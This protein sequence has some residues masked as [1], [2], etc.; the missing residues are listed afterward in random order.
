MV[1]K[2]IWFYSYSDRLNLS[3]EEHESLDQAFEAARVKEGGIYV[4]DMDKS[5]NRADR[6]FDYPIEGFG[7]LT[8][9]EFSAVVQSAIGEDPSLS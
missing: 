2:K 9:E 5:S 1:Q 7:H 6:H 8:L 3:E 4:V